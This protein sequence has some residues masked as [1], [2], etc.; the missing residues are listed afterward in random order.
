[1]FGPTLIVLLAIATVAFA[2]RPVKGGTYTGTFAHGKETIT[3][4]VSAS[5]KSVTVNAPF[6]PALL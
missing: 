4:R 5:G 2:A 3:L 1:M 6:A